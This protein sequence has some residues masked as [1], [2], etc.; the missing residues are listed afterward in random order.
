[1]TVS[2]VSR[3]NQVI[4]TTY[5]IKLGSNAITQWA[6]TNHM[7]FHLYYITGAQPIFSGYTTP[8]THLYSQFL[9]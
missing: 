4:Y 8:S 3:Q 5:Y 2:G 1:M 9:R 6:V 7:L